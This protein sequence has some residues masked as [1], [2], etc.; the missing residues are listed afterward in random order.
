MKTLISILVVCLAAASHAATYPNSATTNAIPVSNRTTQTNRVALGTDA[1]GD[2]KDSGLKLN[3][4]T[5]N[6]IAVA[7]RTTKTNFTILATDANGDIIQGTLTTLAGQ[8]T[9]TLGGTGGTNASVDLAPV[10]F[11]TN[12]FY[13]SLTTNA[14]FTQPSNLTAGKSFSVWVRQDSTGG[15]SVLFDTNYWKLP[16]GQILTTTTNASRT[17]LLSCIV[18]PFGTNVAVIQTLDLR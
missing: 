12:V 16:T 7:D 9:L 10:N 13:C 15:R 17:S 18:M 6:Q 1:N 4:S 14:Y 5:T 11:A 8:L 2:V 3:S